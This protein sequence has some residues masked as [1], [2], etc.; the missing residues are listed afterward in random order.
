MSE[1]RKDFRE[2]QSEYYWSLPRVLLGITVASVL[3]GSVG[4]AINLASQP[5]RIVAKTFDAGNVIHNYEWFHD[6]NANYLARKAQVDQFKALY[7]TETEPAERNRLRMEMAAMQSSCREL[8]RNYNANA[9]K[10]NR[11]MFRGDTL[12]E[13][14]NAGACE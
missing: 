3:L 1:Y 7:S 12:P 9:T 8:A 10:I 6:V 14:L 2:V 4:Y 13:T 11:G 5:A